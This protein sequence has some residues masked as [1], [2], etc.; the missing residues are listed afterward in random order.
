MLFESK[1]NLLSC[2]S[3]GILG[4]TPSTCHDSARSWP[5]R[6]LWYASLAEITGPSVGR[7]MAPSNRK[8]EELCL[9][10]HPC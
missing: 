2:S 4:S 7:F 6:V 5:D 3:T 8:E 1:M 9:R 10:P